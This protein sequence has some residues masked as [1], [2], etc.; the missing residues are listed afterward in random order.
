M[1]KIGDFGMARDISG[2]ECYIKNK[3]V[4]IQNFALRSSVGGHLK[5]LSSM[6]FRERF[7]SS[8]LLQK[9]SVIIC[10]HFTVMCKFV[11]LCR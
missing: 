7:Q 10:S 6:S 8:G 4:S 9:P 3:E 5:T 11:R 2:E 1:L